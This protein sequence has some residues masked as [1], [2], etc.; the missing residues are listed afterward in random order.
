MT[1]LLRTR[2]WQGFTALVIVAI[3]AF[4]LL[5]AWQWARAEERRAERLA[6]VSAA[7]SA[8]V[9]LGGDLAGLAGLATATDEWQ[10]VRVTGRYAPGTTT[11]VRQRPLDGRNGFWVVT[12]F[13]GLDGGRA[14]VNRGWIPAGAAA[15]STVTAP[16][17]PTGT[18]DLIA[19]VRPAQ[20]A[21]Q[22]PPGD[23]PPGQVSHLDPVLLDSLAPSAGGEAANASTTLERVAS[24]PGDPEV[25]ALPLP[26][27]DEGRNISYAVQWILFAVV[28]VAGWWFFLRREARE[29]AGSPQDAAA[30]TSPT[31]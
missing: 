18:V 8:P 13:D 12:A 21:P 15:A 25:Q 29:D 27:I 3:V 7:E 26:T 22:P 4:G 31:P 23:L 28:A 10:A 5:S 2:R 1:G 20:S 30:A 16:E 17:A 14:W 6:V 24:D 19:R 11:L 9:D